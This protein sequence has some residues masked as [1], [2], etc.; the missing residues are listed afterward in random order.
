M[1]PA[2]LEAVFCGIK[3]A[4][5]KFGGVDAAADA[6]ALK[7]DR[8]KAVVA[9]KMPVPPQWVEGFIAY[10]QGEVGST[11]FIKMRNKFL[12]N[13]RR[14]SRVSASKNGSQTE[15]DKSKYKLIRIFG[16][17]RLI[18]PTAKPPMGGLYLDRVDNRPVY[19]E[20]RLRNTF[21]GV[22][23]CEEY[24]LD[25]DKKKAAAKA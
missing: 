16:Q 5:D 20:G 6:L 15:F 8:L 7:A 12:A 21:L 10:G 22:P 11:G 23:I 3:I 1:E 9:R 4:L 24:L 25:F 14:T 17:F 13:Q 19:F 18:P 2:K